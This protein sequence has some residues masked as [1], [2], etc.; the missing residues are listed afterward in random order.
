HPES[1]NWFVHVPF[2]ATTYHAEIGFYDA[3]GIWRRAAVSQKTLTPPEAPSTDLSAEFATIPAEVSFQQVVEA[4]QQFVTVS[5]N[6]P[7][8]E[9]VAQ[10]SE[11]QREQLAI[12]QIILHEQPPIPRVSKT[13]IGPASDLPRDPHADRKRDPLPIKII[14]AEEW[15]EEQS[16]ALS[17]LIHIDSFRRVWM[18]SMEITELVR[19]QLEEEIT[20]IN[21][22]RRKRP[23]VAAEGRVPLEVTDISSPSGGEFSKPGNF[24]FKINAELIIYG[25]TEPD[26]RV[27]IAD[28]L[29]KL[30]PDGTFSFRFSLPDGSYQLPAVAISADAQDGR[31]ARLEFSRTTDYRGHVE[32]H[33]QNAALRPPRPDHLE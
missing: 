25:A 15:S 23:A 10:A 18:G 31:E 5:Q 19:R 12:P 24:W 13:R 33:P 6:E 21:A 28:R 26:A 27:T 11:A 14:P 22:A 7:L 1:K 20:S 2:A 8:L 17:R 32:A 16:A 9:A 29:I 30:R 4:V 3:A